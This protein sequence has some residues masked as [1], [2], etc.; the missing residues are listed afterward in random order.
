M[1]RRRKYIFAIVVS[2]LVVIIGAAWGV[3][4]RSAF[5]LQDETIY[6]AVA[7][8]MSGPDQLE[9]AAMLNGINLYLEHLRQ[10]GGLPGTRIELS[11]HDDQNDELMAEAA[12][13]RIAGENNALLVLGHSF[14]R[15][16]IAAGNV[17]KQQEIPAITA[18][19]LAEAVTEDNDWY[20]RTIPTNTVQASFLAY[21]V[22]TSLNKSSVGVVY[23][24]DTYGRSLLHDFELTARKLNLRILKEWEISSDSDDSEGRVKTIVAD[25]READEQ[26]EVIFLAAYGT[27]AAQLIVAL[28]QL[29]QPYII[30]G[31]DD[32]AGEWFLDELKNVPQERRQPGA[33]SDGVFATTPFLPEIAGERAL[34]F[35]NDFKQTY[36]KTPFWYEACYYD[37]MH[38]AVEAIKRAGLQGRGHLYSDRKRLRDALTTFY[39]LDSAAEGITG[40]LYFNEHGDTIRPFGIGFYQGQRLRPAYRQY[41]AIAEPEHPDTI[42]RD[43]REGRLILVNGRF[44]EN[45]AVVHA[46]LHILDICRLNVEDSTYTADFYLWFRFQEDFHDDQIE[47]LNSVGPVTLGEPV[48]EEKADTLITRA[49]RVK[50]TFQGQFDFRRY[51]FDEHALRIGFRHAML[52]AKDLIYAQD[53]LGVPLPLQKTAGEDVLADSLNGW[54]LGAVTTSQGMFRK[55]ATFG[56]PQFFTSPATLQFSELYADIDV[57]RTDLAGFP[58]YLQSMGVALAFLIGLLALFHKHF[59]MRVLLCVLAL[60]F[61]LYHHT[62]LNAAIIV[63]Y[64]TTW[65]WCI[66]AGY[67][68]IGGI[69][70]ITLLRP[71]FEAVQKISGG[72]I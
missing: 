52:T 17:Y 12:A 16:S 64:L 36:Q 20:F 63:E 53:P 38:I 51:P 14:S 23:E 71:P 15:Q 60:L 10:A 55:S 39:S 40:P 5:Q 21:Y 29:E 11:V 2:I 43:T 35:V 45:M 8:P 42:L 65:E 66:L 33:Y 28:R 46:G 9:G 26:P 56:M 72:N 58:W 44:M 32:L 34:T 25:L 47:F 70:I 62:R 1:T 19:S 30:I 22:K 31:A 27:E 37:A 54:N 24:G 7:G 57:T 13:R 4:R 41:H 67:G 3:L 18:S 61:N 50:A 49:Y 48:F 6:I 59:S 69:L 68:L